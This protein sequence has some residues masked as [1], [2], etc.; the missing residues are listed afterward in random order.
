MV[1]TYVVGARTT[2]F[3]S[4]SGHTCIVYVPMHSHTTFGSTSRYLAAALYCVWNQYNN[5]LPDQ[6]CHGC[7]FM[8]YSSLKISA[9][10]TSVGGS[11]S[12][13]QLH[14]CFQ[15]EKYVTTKRKHELLLSKLF[16]TCRVSKLQSRKISFLLRINVLHAASYSYRPSSN[17]ARSALCIVDVV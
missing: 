11:S 7:F 14:I 6:I 1:C 15:L 17:D 3:V 10:K 5:N 8:A 12:Q 13:I 9:R 16:P 2:K 4:R